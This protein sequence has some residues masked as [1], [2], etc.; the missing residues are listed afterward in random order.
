MAGRRSFTLPA[1]KLTK[2]GRGGK[3]VTYLLRTLQKQSHNE[4]KEEQQ[5][6]EPDQWPQDDNTKL[7]HLP[8]PEEDPKINVLEMKAAAVSWEQIRGNSS[9]VES[10]GLLINTRFVGLGRGKVGI[11]EGGG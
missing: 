5:L 7:F 3:S 6:L 4:P 2:H 1:L 11:E 10:A 9:I 8:L